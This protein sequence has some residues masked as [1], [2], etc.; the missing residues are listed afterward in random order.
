MVPDQ[1]VQR[2]QTRHTVEKATPDQ[3]PALVVLDLDVVMGLGPVIP[4]EQRQLTFPCLD[5][6]PPSRLEETWTP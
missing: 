6:A 5:V 4:D 3:D 1:R 2:G